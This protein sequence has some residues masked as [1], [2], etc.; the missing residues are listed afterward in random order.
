MVPL[1]SEPT[2]PVCGMESEEQA[3]R[4]AASTVAQRS[5]RNDDRMARTDECGRIAHGG[6]HLN[7]R[8]TDCSP[9]VNCHSHDLLSLSAGGRTLPAWIHC[10]RC[11]AMA[12]ASVTTCRSSN[13]PG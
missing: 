4:M 10:R 12:S 1:T 9:F 5:R 2:G 8:R 3:A 13:D 7:E 11:P 6:I